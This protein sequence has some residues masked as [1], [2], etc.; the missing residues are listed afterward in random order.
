M[1]RFIEKEIGGEWNS[2]LK[3]EK[4][5][6][7][8][9]DEKDTEKKKTTTTGKTKTTAT[10]AP[11]LYVTAAFRYLTER[12]AKGLPPQSKFEVDAVARLMRAKKLAKELEGG[13]AVYM[14]AVLDYLAAEVLDLAGDAAAEDDNAHIIAPKH[15]KVA[16][17][18]DKEL[19]ALLESVA[20]MKV[21]KT[22]EHKKAA[23]SPSKTKRPISECAQEA[24][25]TGI[26]SA[27]SVPDKSP[28]RKRQRKCDVADSPRG[29]PRGGGSY[30]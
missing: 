22:D 19:R 30:E 25:E 10:K 14:A 23:S 7:K 16:I 11:P 4:E 2:T 29:D 13:A 17:A 26:A 28:D 12:N 20:P 8:K 15:L 27:V 24:A 1:N 21:Q 6:K 18:K 9:E 3:Q 5:K